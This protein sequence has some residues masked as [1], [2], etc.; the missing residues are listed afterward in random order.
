MFQ[1]Y[2]VTKSIPFRRL[3]FVAA[4]RERQ[5][6]PNRGNLAVSGAQNLCTKGTAFN[7]W[8]CLSADFSTHSLKFTPMAGMKLQ[9]CENA[10]PIISYH[11]S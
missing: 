9:E 7:P 11:G 10:S 1:N 4:D 8:P 2:T 5:T 6:F 3:N